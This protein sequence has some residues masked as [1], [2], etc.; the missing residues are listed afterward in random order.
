MARISVRHI[1]DLKRIHVEPASD[2][3]GLGGCTTLTQIW[4]S[5]LL[6]PQQNS[7]VYAIN[8]TT[9]AVSDVPTG[10]W[11]LTEDL[12]IEG[13]ITLG[14]I[15]AERGGD[16]DEVRLLSNFETFLNLRGNG[17]SLSFENTRVLSWD[18]AIDGPDHDFSDGRSYVSCL[19][20][21]ITDESLSPSCERRAE[22]CVGQYSQYNMLGPKVLIIR[23][24][25]TVV[26]SLNK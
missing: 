13:G 5:L 21:I 6:L 14:V 20:E 4:E 15:G 17:G 1:P 25:F 12:Y 3:H 26:Y 22:V 24:V 16:A 9:N 19:S 7:P 10:T 23:M 8:T 18:D 2:S 11:L